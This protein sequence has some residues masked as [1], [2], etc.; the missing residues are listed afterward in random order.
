MC[1]TDGGDEEEATADGDASTDNLGS[2]CEP[3]SWT[4]TEIQCVVEPGV[5]AALPVGIVAG[6]HYYVD[7]VTRIGDSGR[8]LSSSRFTFSYD[9]PVVNLVTPMIVAVEG[10]E[11]VSI[12]G[13]NFGPAGTPVSV[14]PEWM[15]RCDHSNTSHTL[16]TCITLLGRGDGLAVHVTVEGQRSDAT[17]GGGNTDGEVDRVGASV[18]I[19]YFPPLI[20]SV[21]PN[22]GAANSPEKI[23]IYGNSFGKSPTNV[24]AFIGGRPC[25]N[26]AWMPENPPTYQKSYIQCNPPDRDVSGKKNITLIFSDD[27]AFSAD[28]LLYDPLHFDGMYVE[29]R[30]IN[31]PNTC[32]ECR[33]VTIHSSPSTSNI[34]CPILVVVVIVAISC[35]GTQ[36]PVL[37]GSTAL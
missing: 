15:L 8:R 17:N 30:R 24:R 14:E 35:S 13:D 21:D 34:Y 16:I 12:Q 20:T 29:E 6:G 2:W 36:S 1:S 10:G 19:S 11:H 5:G 9:R 22:R 18:N 23:T 27:D 37:Q 3:L 4:H 28:K 31:A 7:N 25:A 26:A 32:C 33:L